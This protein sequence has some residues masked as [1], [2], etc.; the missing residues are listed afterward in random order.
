MP[1]DTRARVISEVGCMEEREGETL[2]FHARGRPPP[3]GQSEDPS[4][5]RLVGPSTLGSLI[6][7]VGHSEILIKEKDDENRLIH[8][9]LCKVMGG[10][11]LAGAWIKHQ[12]SNCRN[13]LPI[14]P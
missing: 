10:I 5:V 4:S 9:E 6:R 14:I 1:G 2:I 12:D 11:I 13:W 7:R 3:R 8:R